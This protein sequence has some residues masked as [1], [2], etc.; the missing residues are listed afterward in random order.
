MDIQL[1]IAMVSTLLLRPSNH[2]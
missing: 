1:Y 2:V